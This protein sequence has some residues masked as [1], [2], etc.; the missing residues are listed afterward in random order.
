MPKLDST[1]LMPTYEYRCGSGH[2]FEVVQR[3]TDDP[4]STCQVCGERVQRIFRP[5]AVHFK[6]SGFYTT[7]YARSSAG[8]GKTEGDSGANGKDSK[9]KGEAKASSGSK[10]SSGSKD[11]AASK[12]SSEPTGSGGKSAAGGGD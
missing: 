8:E 1:S 5:V 11:S 10:E 9:S 12:G 2:E 3:M 7:D 6:G 4:V